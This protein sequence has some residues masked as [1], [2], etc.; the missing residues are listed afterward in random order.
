MV[1]I[2]GDNIENGNATIP[3]ILVNDLHQCTIVIQSNGITD[4][5]SL[6]WDRMLSNEYH[7]DR[8]MKASIV[9]SR[10]NLVGELLKLFEAE[11]GH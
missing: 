7:Y 3:K 4:H 8:Q 5:I 11:V 6:C 2:P 10:Y 9:I 1:L